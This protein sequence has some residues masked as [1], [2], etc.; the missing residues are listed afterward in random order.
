M[1]RVKENH[2]VDEADESGEATKKEAV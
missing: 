1:V 2:T